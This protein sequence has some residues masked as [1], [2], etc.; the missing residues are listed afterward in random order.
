MRENKRAQ[1]LHYEGEQEKKLNISILSRSKLKAKF[2][3]F[4]DEN[5]LILVVLSGR[6]QKLE[7]DFGV[8][9]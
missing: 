2:F 7:R 5:R 9:F 3:D 8:L 4:L 6:F 1:V